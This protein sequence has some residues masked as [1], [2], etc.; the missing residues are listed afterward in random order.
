MDKSTKNSLIT[1]NA[2]VVP[3]AMLL[4]F[5]AQN[6]AV[7]AA[8]VLGPVYA[9]AVVAADV[10]LARSGTDSAKVLRRA[11]RHTSFKAES[12]EFARL[13]EEIRSRGAMLSGCGVPFFTGFYSEILTSAENLV[14]DITGF[15]RGS[16]QKDSI[17][18]MYIDSRAGEME[19]LA[20]RANM[21]AVAYMDYT[22]NP[23]T[24]LNELN[25]RIR[26]DLAAYRA[27][28][29]NAVPMTDDE[30][31]KSVQGA[32]HAGNFERTARLVN[33]YR[34]GYSGN[35][36][37]FAF[38][39]AIVGNIPGYAV[40]HSPEFRLDPGDG[41]ASPYLGLC[42]NPEMTAL[43]VSLGAPR[44]EKYYENT[45]FAFHS[46]TGEV[47]AVSE[48]F[49]ISAFNTLNG[50][51]KTDKDVFLN[52]FRGRY[53]RENTAVKIMDMLNINSF[54]KK[55]LYEDLCKKL[56]RHNRRERNK[57][58]RAEIPDDCRAKITGNGW[59]LK[60]IFE[61]LGYHFEYEGTQ[62]PFRGPGVCYI[63]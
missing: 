29:E 55:N 62:D 13:Y 14:K 1:V 50:L 51:V 30:I 18:M 21:L 46:E 8:A 24:D 19:L 54:N 25:L 45:S 58:T 59:D 53:Y 28:R 36:D 4:T 40:L 61:S 22:K 57:V 5:L 48:E 23:E 56:A 10:I 33:D 15:I 34:E 35:L 63:P 17:N 43:L 44:G 37:A 32:L 9:A 3:A 39:T 2:T 6:A 12:E 49:V 60:Y 16:G 38:E 42:N 52:F 27:N 41:T 20:E 47:F 11:G 31:R 7:A 26:S